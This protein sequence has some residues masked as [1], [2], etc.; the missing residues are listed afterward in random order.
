MEVFWSLCTTVYYILY[1]FYL[2]LIMVI[3][4]ASAL[5]ISIFMESST[6]FQMYV[7]LVLLV[8][9]WAAFLVLCHPCLPPDLDRLQ[10]SVRNCPS[11]HFNFPV[12]I[13]AYWSSS[14]VI[15][16]ISG[17]LGRANVNPALVQEV[18]FGNVLS[19][20]LGQ[21]PARQAAL[22]AGLPN[23]VVCTT[24]NKVCAAGMKGMDQLL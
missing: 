4:K 6:A 3:N 16:N 18:F 22:G 12:S 11:S 9:L 5:E 15:Q 24:I 20:N 2:Y 23:T 10:F 8:P 1:I 19:A 21:A 13:V 14:D 7:L 17:A